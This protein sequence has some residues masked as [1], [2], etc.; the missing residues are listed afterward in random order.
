MR[1]LCGAVAWGYLAS[2]VLALAVIPATGAGLFGLEPNAFVALYAIVLGVPWSF[3]SMELTSGELGVAGSM[4]L[5]AVGMVVN[6][7][8]LRWL[9][10]RLG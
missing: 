3:L 8:G 6:W 2:C 4:A 10:R 5:I 9:C 1:R 7:A